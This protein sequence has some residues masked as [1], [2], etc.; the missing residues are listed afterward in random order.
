M[1]R[2]KTVKID[3]RIS[4]RDAKRLNELMKMGDWNRS[5]ALRFVLNFSY[6]VMDMMP[7]ALFETFI[8]GIETSVETDKDS[9]D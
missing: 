4:E 9:E 3:L 2:E 8:D 5:E 1:P 7:A 6:V